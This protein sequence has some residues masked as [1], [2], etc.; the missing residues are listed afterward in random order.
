MVG[1]H[2]GWAFSGDS[3]GRAYHAL[4]T[5]RP[6][7]ELAVVFGSHRGPSGPNTVFRGDSWDTPLGAL[8]NDRALAD[9]L[10][11]AL[12][13]ETEPV[14]PLRPD[15]GV[16]LHLPFVK[17][18]WP[19]AKLL[20]LGIAASEIALEIGRAVGERIR[21]RDAVVIGSTDLTHYGPN[22]GFAPAGRGEAAV[23]WAR[24][25]NDVGFIDAL[26]R[27]APAEALRHAREHSSACCPGAAVAAFEAVR[28]MRG[29]VH[30]E[31]LDHTLSYDV[32]PD[33]SFVG[34]AGIVM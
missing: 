12:G 27:D 8:E 33:A 5:A 3:A 19:D 29:A 26:L 10:A 17:Y 22:Y 18:F 2:A 32:R 13:L 25:V 23:R 30:P 14:R 6:D 28:A 9:A 34:Y 24:E 15:N 31:L 7:A 16:E 21:G 4:A 20:M 1:P 11:E